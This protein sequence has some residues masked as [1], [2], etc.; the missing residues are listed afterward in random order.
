[1]SMQNEIKQP[2]RL[3]DQQGHITNPGWARQLHWTYDRKDIKA[4]KWRIKE[5]DYYLVT[6]DSYGVAFT[7][8][9]LGYIGMASVSFLNFKEGW[10]HTETSLVLFPLGKYGL[11]SH[12]DFG[13]AQFQNKKMQLQY[14]VT[15]GKR[16][17]RCHY[18]D[19]YQGQNLDAEIV[20]SQPPMDT[21]CIATPWKEK[22]TAFYY[23]QKINCMPAAGHVGL[24]SESY[25][26]YADR[27][28]GILDWG[29][30]VW[31]YDNVWYWGTGSGLVNG[32]PFGLN[33]GY[34]FSDRSSASENMLF[35]NGVGHKL[36]LVKFQIPTCSDGSYDFL[37]EWEIT[38]DD[39]RLTGL[40]TPVLNR[41]AHI[42]VLMIETEQNQIFGHFNGT[43][44][45]DDGTILDITDFFC[46][47]EV[48][49]NRY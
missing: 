20:L 38:S 32:V 29:R 42:H 27:D 11:G 9:D 45:L 34:G 2:I 21:M 17:L 16:T 4:P 5:W 30:G 18:T 24:G 41:Q 22:P 28:F 35:Y 39:N 49:H 40:F 43:A 33:L 37:K 13:N 8:S 19:F 7:I 25:Q 44:V 3:L 15:K 12:S 1:M 26:F 14:V 36:N 10:E 48:I 6:N 23:N 31:T 47:I 46:G